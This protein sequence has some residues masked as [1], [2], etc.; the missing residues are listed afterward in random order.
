MVD[1]IIIKAFL[2]VMEVYTLIFE[3]NIQSLNWAKKYYWCTQNAK[4]KLILSNIEIA[5][6]DFPLLLL[7]HQKK[8][9]LSLSQQNGAFN[10]HFICTKF[11]H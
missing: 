3:N 10:L 4:F 9:Q 11:W 7:L 1:S 2:S 6:L 5:M 8:R